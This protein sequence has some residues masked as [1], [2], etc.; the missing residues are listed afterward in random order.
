MKRY[1]LALYSTDGEMVEAPSGDYVRHEDVLALLKRVLPYVN[2][3]I[4]QVWAEAA[5]PES[6]ALRDEIK[7]IIGE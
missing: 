5:S 4:E 7:A 2:F 3:A 6:I 1:D